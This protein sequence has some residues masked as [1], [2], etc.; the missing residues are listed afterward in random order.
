MPVE[1]HRYA[2][3]L[4]SAV[5]EDLVAQ[6]NSA[7][8]MQSRVI[9]ALG[10]FFGTIDGSGAAATDYVLMV[11]PQDCTLVDIYLYD[12]IGIAA[13]STR[14]FSFS[15]NGAAIF[16]IVGAAE[17]DAVNGFAAGALYKAS[18]LTGVTTP[19]AAQQL[20]ADDV[21]TVNINDGTVNMQMSVIAVYRPIKDTI[22]IRPAATTTR[23]GTIQAA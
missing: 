3:D 21:L 11:A 22:A 5:V 16:G 15:V 23:A 4:G 1:N 18:E 14:V 13:A 19:F 9:V 10:G 6:V 8:V 12:P 7:V 2:N 17:V 20:E